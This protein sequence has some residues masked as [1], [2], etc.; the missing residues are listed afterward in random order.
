MK[1]YFAKSTPPVPKH[2]AHSGEEIGLSGSM[3][4]ALS[5][6]ILSNEGS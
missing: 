2:F 5:P 4:K 6:R 1:L 3:I